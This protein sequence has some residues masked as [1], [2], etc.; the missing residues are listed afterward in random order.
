MKFFISYRFTGEDLRKLKPLLGSMQE[1]LTTAGHKNYCSFEW[2]SHFVKNNFSNAQIL[3]HSL[4]EL[5]NSDVLL[6]FIN[7]PEK[8]E[9]MLLEIGYALAKKKRLYVLIRK[10]V[11]T[12]FVLEMADKVIEFKDAGEIPHF[13]RPL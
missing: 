10:G 5:D 13:L 4:N 9:G 7:S 11:K 1:A 6:A 12:T 2:Q 8:S 3:R